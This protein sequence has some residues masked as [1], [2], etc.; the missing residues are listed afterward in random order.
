MIS[1]PLPNDM[2]GT[3]QRSNSHKYDLGDL[4]SHPTGS[5]TWKPSTTNKNQ[6]LEVR[7][8]KPSFVTALETRGSP[9]DGQYVKTYY[10]MYRNVSTGL[11]M[12]YKVSRQI[13]FPLKILS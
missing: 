3:S 10:M 4:K 7:L 5:K 1:V 9:F 12:D 8:D 13:P 6:Y 11:Y 2:T